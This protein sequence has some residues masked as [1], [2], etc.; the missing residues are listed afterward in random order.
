M[1]KQCT[2]AGCLNEPNTGPYKDCHG[3]VSGG[4]GSLAGCNASSPTQSPESQYDTTDAEP[5]IN[6]Y[7][8]ARQKLSVMA[9]GLESRASHLRALLRALPQEMSPEAEAGLKHIINAGML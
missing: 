6:P 7:L 4:L 3:Y 8:T 2:R 5:R 1:D 9:G